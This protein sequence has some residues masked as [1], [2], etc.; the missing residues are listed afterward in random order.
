MLK[1][2]DNRANAFITG[3]TYLTELSHDLPQEAVQDRKLSS[4]IN[5]SLKSPGIAYAVQIGDLIQ[6]L[7]HGAP[8]H[9]QELIHE[10]HILLLTA[11]P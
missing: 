11:K 8:F 7:L 3:Y 5:V 2:L 10:A 4:Q 1:S 9:L 6:E